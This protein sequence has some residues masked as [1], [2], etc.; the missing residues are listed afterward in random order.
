MSDRDAEIARLQKEKEDATTEA[1]EERET[2]VAQIEAGGESM[3]FAKQL[4]DTPRNPRAMT[5]IPLA[6]P[7]SAMA[8]PTREKRSRDRRAA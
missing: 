1:A 2:L 6:S 5:R 7:G 4:Q 8:G 3:E